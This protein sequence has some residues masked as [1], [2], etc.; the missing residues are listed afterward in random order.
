M[1]SAYGTGS[2]TVSIR[3]GPKNISNVVYVPDLKTNLLSVNKMI[4]NG[5][6]VFN[7]TRYQIYDAEGC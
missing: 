2:V 6:V 3:N 7:S 4:K 5:Y 1:V